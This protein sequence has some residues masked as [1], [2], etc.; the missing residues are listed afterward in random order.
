MTSESTTSSRPNL[1][2]RLLELLSDSIVYGLSTL[3]A[4]VAGFL[5]LPLYTRHLAP[6]DY[7]VLAMLN[8][9]TMTFTPLSSF[10]LGSGASR[11]INLQPDHPGRGVILTTVALGSIAISGSFLIL[12]WLTAQYPA[13]W[14]VGTETAVPLVRLTML[15]AVF[16]ILGD[17]ARIDLRCRRRTKTV[18]LLNLL[19]FLVTMTVTIRLVVVDQVGVAGVVW[20]GLTGALFGTIGSFWAARRH[21]TLGFDRSEFRQMFQYGWPLVPHRLVSVGL[22]CY[23]Q[24]YVREMLGL[25]EAGLF[26]MAARFALPIGL[27]VNA[28]QEAWSPYKFQVH[29]QEERPQTFFRE[30]FTYYL[31]LV[32]YL[33]VGVAAW[34][35]EA[36]RLMT[37]AKF[38]AAAGLVVLLGLTRVSWGIYLMMGSGVELGSDTRPLSLISFTGLV[39]VVVSTLWLV[40]LCGAAGAAVSTTLGYLT[41]AFMARRLARMRFLIHYD[42]PR[43]AALTI[44]AIACVA[45]TYAALNTSFGIRIIAAA[46]V[47]LAYPFGAWF[48]VRYHRTTETPWRLRTPVEVGS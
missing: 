43:A 13:R 12:G 22:T 3:L 5:L 4:Q 32:L 27:A 35:P 7:G 11:R 20:G 47:S 18:G 30:L 17:T 46:A 10:C 41:M 34:G 28:I 48:I 42:W 23:S 44:A 21:F 14:I 19:S 33:W 2:S 37:E 24:F 26:D 29:A 9:I 36:L 8:V 25:Y 38:H 31:A 39:V 1:L 16:V 45:V 40:P 6:A 15:T